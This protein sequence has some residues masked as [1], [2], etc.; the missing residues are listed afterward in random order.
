MIVQYGVCA[1]KKTPQ[2]YVAKPFNFYIYGGDN[3]NIQ[4]QRTFLSNASSLSFL[5]SNHFDFNKLIDQ[6]I[7]FYN[8]TEEGSVYTT[9]GGFDVIGRQNIASGK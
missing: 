6:G 1:F 8:Y 4:S 9:S 5:R 3:D 7:P 2:G